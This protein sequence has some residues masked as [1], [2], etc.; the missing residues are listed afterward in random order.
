M[1]TKRIQKYLKVDFKTHIGK[2]HG[3]PDHCTTHALGVPED[4]Q[5]QGECELEHDVECSR[6]SS[7]KVVLMKIEQATSNADMPADQHL[8][9]RHEFI[10]N[11]EAI[12]AWKSHLL[13]TVNQEE[14]KQDVLHIL[15]K[16]S[17]LVIMD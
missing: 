7:L 11:C 15:D 3:S 8:R 1:Q 9:L 16:E 17:C 6:C 14:S 2:E 12:K 5:L 13:P 10:Q 4:P